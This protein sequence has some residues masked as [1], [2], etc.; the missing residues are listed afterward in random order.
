MA[1]CQ[2]CRTG[3]NAS[4]KGSSCAACVAGR[5]RGED[6]DARARVR[7]QHAARRLV[8]HAAQVATDSAI[9]QAGEVLTIGWTRGGKGGGVD[10]R[11]GE[12][13]HGRGRQR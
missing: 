13:A 10:L 11:R 2:G 9:A 6:D 8:V 4:T 7:T 3:F 12:G 1:Y 5:Y